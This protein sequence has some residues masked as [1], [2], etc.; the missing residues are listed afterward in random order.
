MLILAGRAQPEIA[1]TIEELLVRLGSLRRRG[2][3]RGRG[4]AGPA[5]GRRARE[6]KINSKA[7]RY[8]NCR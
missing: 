3:A 4:A 8:L 6:K 7:I 5:A 2:G 1:E